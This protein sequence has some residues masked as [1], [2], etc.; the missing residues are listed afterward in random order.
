M[1]AD[2]SLLQN[3]VQALEPA[4]VEA[5][6]SFVAPEPA[7]EASTGQ[8]L[9]NIDLMPTAPVE[10]KQAP[11]PTI[12]PTVPIWRDTSQDFGSGAALKPEVANTMLPSFSVAI[13]DNSNALNQSFASFG[14]A[15]GAFNQQAKEQYAA[16]QK[17]QLQVQKKG[18]LPNTPDATKA[19]YAEP[20]GFMS[21]VLFGTEKA[22]K[23]S[24]A[25]IVDNRV[26]SFGRAGSGVGGSINYAL[27]LLPSAFMGL[28][29]EV[30]KRVVGALETVG[31]KKET[32]EGF[33]RDGFLTFLPDSPLKPSRILNFNFDE[34]NKRNLIVDAI[35]GD[36]LNDVNEPDGS[37]KYGRIYTRSQRKQGQSAIQDPVGFALQLGTYLF[38]PGEIPGDRLISAGVGKLFSAFKKPTT[39]AAQ[40]SVRAGVKVPDVGFNPSATIEQPSLLNA[41]KPRL[42]A[43]APGGAIEFTAPQ[44]L[45]PPRLNVGEA[46]L[47]YPTNTKLPY[48]AQ[49]QVVPRAYTGSGEVTRAALPPAFDPA[50]VPEAT[51]TPLLPYSSPAK[52]ALEVGIGNP[53]VRLEKAGALALRPLAEVL[54][55]L[56]ETNPKLLEGF[57]GI[58]WED[59]KLHMSDKLPDIGEVSAI[60]EDLSKPVRALE[61]APE[62][63]VNAVEEATQKRS[64]ITAERV[65]K[66][67]DIKEQ[68]SESSFAAIEKLD[69]ATKTKESLSS[70]IER[71][72][73]LANDAIENEIL[74]LQEQS[75]KAIKETADEI[76]AMMKEGASPEQLERATQALEGY[77]TKIENHLGKLLDQVTTLKKAAENLKGNDY[78]IAELKYK[79]ALENIKKTKFNNDLLLRNLRVG[80]DVVKR[81]VI[82]FT[83]TTDDL[84]TAA[85]ELARHKLASEAPL[86][87]LDDLF[88]ETVDFGRKPVDEVAFDIIDPALALRTVEEGG[89][90]KLNPNI[91]IDSSKLGQR[92]KEAWL[93]GDYDEVLNLSRKQGV[94]FKDAVEEVVRRNNDYILAANRVRNVQ[95]PAEALAKVDGIL[96]HGTVVDNWTPPQNL[97]VNGSRGELGGGTYFTTN[98][99][100]ANDYAR[101]RV[102]DNVSPKTFDSDI[103]PAVA[104]VQP[105]FSATLD[106]RKPLAKEALKAVFADLPPEVLKKFSAVV[107]KKKKPIDYVSLRGIMEDSFVKAGVEPT[108]ELLQQA[109]A[110]IS[111]NLRA[112]GFDSVADT[113][114][115]FVLSLDNTRVKVLELINVP[116]PSL[117][118]S[119]IARFNADAEA[120]KYYDNLLTSDANMR[121][122]TYKYHAQVAAGT[123][124][125]LADV[126][127]EVIG[128]GLP[129]Q[130]T[131]L[132]KLETE[133][134]RPSSFVEAIDELTDEGACSI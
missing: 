123:D 8:E 104:E 53:N 122:S 131:I 34:A 15:A 3:Q 91:F 38:N 120:A 96:Y 99:R 59:F 6:G 75:Q 97:Y 33:A 62:V 20:L 40:G 56:E 78:F 94:G 13:P 4:P 49:P 79:Q 5:V 118:E 55:A 87:Q 2:E 134:S 95:P 133:D 93:S 12:L 81:P 32:A 36:P 14:S 46:V 9:P 39:E 117:M 41:A 77:S 58:T 112:L 103:N 116:K 125:K 92:L 52:T 50:D 126:Q 82:E 43:S 83:R 7:S 65:Q 18:A 10:I 76:R 44:A 71:Y 100:Q 127:D 27:N 114:S 23:L 109:D 63:V 98:A 124:K 132:P 51:F 48:G 121:D 1:V 16:A 107:N 129:E 47:E 68:V 72:E 45:N 25:G 61:A 67:R 37:V 19:W 101:A 22:K 21:D 108:E 70:S 115:G 69:L 84:L 26:G 11:E 30:N 31:V 85:E 88:D 86:Q 57:D 54:T 90:F 66:I 102:G 80:D 119:T 24:E 89:I 60:G 130:D 42:N 29:G 128:R 106:A 73:T 113:Q 111:K 64:I 110:D 35:A 17:A 105:Q 28:T 74:P